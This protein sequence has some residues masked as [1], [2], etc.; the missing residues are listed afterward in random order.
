MNKPNLYRGGISTK[1]EVQTEKKRRTN[2]PNEK[3]P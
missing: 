1:E 3:A 2:K